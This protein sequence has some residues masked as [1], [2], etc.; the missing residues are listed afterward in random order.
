MPCKVAEGEQQVAWSGFD[1][2]MQ[3]PQLD[4][5]TVVVKGEKLAHYR[6]QKKSFFR[7]NFERRYPENRIDNEVVLVVRKARAS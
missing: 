4:G 3:L 2:S 6:K 1:T 7:R 5:T